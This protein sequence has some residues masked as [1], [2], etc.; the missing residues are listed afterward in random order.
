MK[1]II[2]FFAFSFASI[3]R[4]YD[5]SK[6]K[7]FTPIEYQNAKITVAHFYWKQ[8]ADGTR[9]EVDEE[10]CA[11][12]QLLKIPVLDIRGR[13]EEWFYCHDNQPTVSCKSQFQGVEASIEVKPAIVIRSWQK[14]SARDSHV[15]AYVIP[16]NDPKKYFD[17]FARNISPVLTPQKLVMEAAGGGRGEE[18]GVDSFYVRVDLE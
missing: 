12:K 10:V 13:E 6:F 4:A 7:E 15:H 5:C 8:N 1:F 14:S 3:G 18:S 11:T 9:E 17:L 16:G 2:L